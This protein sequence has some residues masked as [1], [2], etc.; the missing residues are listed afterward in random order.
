MK[1]LLLTSTLLLASVVCTYAEK[2]EVELKISD[3]NQNNLGHRPSRSP[4]LYPDVTIE[5]NILSFSS[6]CINCTIQLIQDDITVYIDYVDENGEVI[7]PTYLSGTYILQF[8]L[9]SIT[10]VGE[11]E[12]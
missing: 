7:L 10:F 8:Q 1:K 4:I 3:S 11:I 12:L 5:D 9:G 6:S 2:K